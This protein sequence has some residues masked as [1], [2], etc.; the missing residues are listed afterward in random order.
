M[1]DHSFRDPPPRPDPINI[2]RPS[3]ATLCGNKSCQHPFSIHF[4]TYDG[5]HTGCAGLISGQRDNDTPC[6]CEGFALVIPWRPA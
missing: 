5:I 2:P 4:T 3:K 6:R 1:A